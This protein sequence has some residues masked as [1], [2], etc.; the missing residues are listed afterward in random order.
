MGIITRSIANNIVTGGKLDG[1]D[2]LSGVISAS[3]IANDSLTNITA[4]S[5]SLG[6]AI[7]SVA[8]DPVSPSEG[9]LWYNTTIGVLKVYRNIGGA[10][11][12][13]GNLPVGKSGMGGAGILTAALGFGC[14]STA[15]TNTTEEYDGSAWAAGGNRSASKS[16]GASGGTQTA[17][18]GA[19]GAPITNLTEE[20]DGT[21]WSPGGNLGTSRYQVGIGTVGTQ[22]A[23]ICIGGF[24]Q[25]TAITNTEEY[26]GST[27][28]AGGSLGTAIRLQAGAGIQTAALSF[29]GYLT[30]N[31]NTNATEEYD[32]ATWTAGGNLN[33]TRRELSGTGAQTA[34]LAV[35]GN[36][37]TG[38]TEEYNGSTWA[39]GGTMVTATND[40]QSAGTNTAGLTFG[41]G[42]SLVTTQEY[43][44]PTIAVQKVTLT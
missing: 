17:A 24:N 3:N 21:S 12:S 39:T 26:N 29:G 18:Y 30:T 22:T 37:V 33:T 31:T 41:G 4:L 14:Y 35:G 25:T 5:S 19:G 8:T 7:E 1:T 6:D 11:A 28:T 38:S 20:Y 9:Q 36:P 44:N 34:A 16:G 32:G 42:G 10:W 15:N 13:G 43:I 2:G 40:N 23:G 27:W